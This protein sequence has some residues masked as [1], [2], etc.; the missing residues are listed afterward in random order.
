LNLFSLKSKK[1]LHFR[2]VNIP[3]LVIV[4]F[5]CLVLTACSTSP[6]SKID[7]R[8]ASSQAPLEVPP[9]LTKLPSDASQNADTYSAYAAER[10]TAKIGTSTVLPDFKN[11]QLERDGD[12]RWIRVKADKK[13]LWVDI[14]NFLGDIGLAIQTENPATGIIETDWAEN[15]ARY[16]QGGG[17]FST[18]FRKF[19]DTGERDK[20]RIR[21]E[22]DSQSG[23]YDVYVAHQGLVEVVTSGG[24]DSIEQTAWTRRP[25][26]PGLE[27]EMLRLMMVYLGVDNKKASELLA[28]GIRKAR[29]VLETDKQDGTRY[30]LVKASLVR[31][32]RRLETTLDRMG[33]QTVASEDGGNLL[34]ITYLLPKDEKINKSG[35]F[36]RL[37][38]GGE[39]K[40]GT[41]RIR[42]NS[43]GEETDLRLV[44]K[45]GKPDT[46]ERA[47]E[48]LEILFDRLK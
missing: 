22:E 28:S 45:N 46:S 38:Q 14:K 8:S 26:D 41:Y 6:T 39:R 47:S 30:I 13:E 17:I 5:V 33:A 44:D 12:I 31:T 43:S 1:L 21:I 34:T 10:Q 20:Y 15:R 29:A 7:Y 4:S 25:S 2:Q 18:L 9:D 3:K 24:G 11:I 27:A 23:W 40:A 19:D 32:Q 48:V 42:I 37:L 36:S 16:G 35:F